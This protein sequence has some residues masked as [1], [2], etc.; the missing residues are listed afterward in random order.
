MVPCHEGGGSTEYPMAGDRS[1]LRRETVLDR[2]G[3]Q[4]VV[5]ETFEDRDVDVDGVRIHAKVGGSGPPV[6]LLH[7]YPQ[8]HAMWH[9]VAP[10]L[11]EGHTVVLADLRGYG[12]SSRPASTPDH[13][14][15]SKRAMAQ[16]QVA[17]MRELGFDRFALVGHD[18]GGRVAHRLCLDHAE[19][20]TRVA[21]LDIVPTRHVFTHVDRALAQAYYHWFFLAQEADLPERLIG[22]DP[23]FYLRRKL[24]QWSGG[25]GLDAFTPDALAE[26]VRCF[27]DPEVIRASCE[28]YRAGASI[29]LEHDEVDAGSGRRVEC[30]VLVLWGAEGF[31]G[32]SYDVVEVWRT[33]ATEVRGQRLGGGHFPAE[34]DPEATLAALRR[35]LGDC[36]PA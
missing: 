23:S 19:A 12:D 15:Y 9:R 13:A 33:Y 34:E 5:F 3:R 25:E 17:L 8:T 1:G 22:S 18:R 14:S 28:D 21:F 30:P 6:L 2:R 7:G 26:Y 4:V 16:D 36:E 35:F 29:D 20:V 32:R 27:S 31:V 24:D 10:G 11:T